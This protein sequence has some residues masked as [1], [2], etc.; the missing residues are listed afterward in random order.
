LGLSDKPTYGRF[1]MKDTILKSLFVSLFLIFASQTSAQESDANVT[2]EQD[3]DWCENFPKCTQSSANTNA[4][5]TEAASQW[6]LLWEK[7]TKE[8]KEAVESLPLPPQPE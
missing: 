7:L 8:M 6:S 1:T 2:D 3:P 4:D 5:E